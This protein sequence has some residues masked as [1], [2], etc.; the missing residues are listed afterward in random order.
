MPDIVTSDSSTSEKLGAGATIASQVEQ[1]NELRE[2]LSSERNAR[3]QCQTQLAE[4]KSVS[5]LDKVQLAE[6]QQEL[7]SKQNQLTENDLELVKLGAEIEQ[8]KLT[9]ADTQSD[10][11]K[12]DSLLSHEQSQCSLARADVT[13]SEHQLDIQHGHPR[14]CTGIA[15]DVDSMKSIVAETE[16]QLIDLRAALKS[17]QQAHQAAK[18]DLARVKAGL[19]AEKSM[20]NITKTSLTTVEQ[21]LLAEKSSHMMTKS[22]L[23]SK[24]AELETEQS[25][26]AQTKIQLVKA[27]A[28]LSN[29]R[30]NYSDLEIDFEKVKA[31]QK[32]LE[33][34]LEASKRAEKRSVDLVAELRVQ[35]QQAKQQLD[36]L[37]ASHKQVVCAMN[38]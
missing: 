25:N 27:E 34:E 18:E 35:V 6:L 15:E 19:A 3:I 4:L 21:D 10:N 11:K 24:E 37:K 14:N 1:L 26:L 16:M 32:R 22:E 31:S 28:D 20:Q 30:R 5:S 23:T 33:M 8:L 13:V 36:G 9:L 7:S 12:L 2:A 29:E 17:E 38:V